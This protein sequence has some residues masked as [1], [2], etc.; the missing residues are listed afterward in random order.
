[1]L[2]RQ[3]LFPPLQV[4]HRLSLPVLLFL[5][6]LLPLL[7]LA[8][9]LLQ[10][11]HVLLNLLLPPVP[12]ILLEHVLLFQLGPPQALILALDPPLALLLPRIALLLP[13]P[14]QL[15]TTLLLQV[16]QLVFRRSRQVLLLMTLSRLQLSL[17]RRLC[18]ITWAFRSSKFRSTRLPCRESS[19]ALSH[20]GTG[21]SSTGHRYV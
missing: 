5:V 6:L 20:C 21:T 11:P 10:L 1:M 13:L 17:H 3:E 12:P 4:P 18:E 14:L 2:V 19:L 9:D 16:P 8:R 7:P 15:C